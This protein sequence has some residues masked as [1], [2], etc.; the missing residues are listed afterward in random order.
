MMPLSISVVFLSS[1][2]VL[3][4]ADRL[5]KFDVAQGCRQA[6]TATTASMKSCLNDEQGARNTLTKTWT[7]F[8]AGAKRNCIDETSMDGTP[9][10]VELLTCLQMAADVKKL[11]AG[12]R[13]FG[14]SIGR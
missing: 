12:T 2:L 9:S 7:Q 6:V 5:P 1:Q 8:S 4:V 14:T 13:G 11:P 3:A 10:Y